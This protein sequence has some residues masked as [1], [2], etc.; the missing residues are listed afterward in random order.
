MQGER[1]DDGRLRRHT[2]A[3]MPEPNDLTRFYWDAVAEH[4]LELLRC[5]SCGHFLHYPRRI[6]NHCLSTDLQPEAVSGKG[7]LYSYCEVMQGSHPYFAARLP[8]LI[9]IIDL[10][11]EPGVRLPTGIVDSVADDLR[12]GIADGGDVPRGDLNADAPLLAPGRRPMRAQEVA[13]VGVGYSTTGRTTGLSSFELARQA[14]MAALDDAGM[15]RD[16]L[17]GVTLLWGVA[18]PAPAGLDVVEPMSFADAMGIGSLELL[19]H[20]RTGVHRPGD[21]RH[22]GDQGRPRPHRSHPAHHQPAPELDGG[23]GRPSAGDRPDARSRRHRVHGAVRLRR[24]RGDP[25]DRRHADAAPHGRLRHD[26]GAVRRPR[27]HPAGATPRSTT[28]RS[29]AT[30]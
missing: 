7:T 6:C 13:A 30:R 28:K 15:T 19:R 16:D 8:Y 21:Q 14:T 20:R 27:H 29:S 2:V 17:D 4:R 11:E 24:G 23:A 9:G 5:R 26:R 10:A 1:D 3:P 22:R 12:C 18:G 25:L